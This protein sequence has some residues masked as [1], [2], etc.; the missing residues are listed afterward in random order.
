MLRRRYRGCAGVAVAVV[1]KVI[2]PVMIKTA[3]SC[4][5]RFMVVAPWCKVR[6]DCLGPSRPLADVLTPSMRRHGDP[7]RHESPLLPAVAPSDLV[8]RELLRLEVEIVVVVP[9]EQVAGRL[10]VLAD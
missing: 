8:F 4:W 7:A 9:L 2:E 6:V 10:G 1:M 5:T 3:V